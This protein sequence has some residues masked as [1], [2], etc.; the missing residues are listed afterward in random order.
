M[1]SDLSFDDLMTRLRQGHNDAA[2][3]V[4]GRF[5]SRLLA[6]ARSRLGPQIRRKEDPEDVLQSVFRSFFHRNAEG[7]FG[8]FDSWDNLWAMLVVMTVRKCGRHIDYFRAAC[9]DVDREESPAASDSYDANRSPSADDPLPSEAAMLTETVEQLMNSLQG[10]HR[11]ILMLSLQ[12]YAPAEISSQVG[13]TER[14]VY[15]VLETVKEWLEARA[16]GG[17]A[18]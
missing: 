11:Q 10:R 2:T 14:T 16:A 1:S 9:R 12:G 4:F 17:P 15:R 18:R 5:A 8:E 3:Q 13:C 7:E 6:L